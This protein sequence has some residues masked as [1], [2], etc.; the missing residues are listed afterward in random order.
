LLGGLFL[1]VLAREQTAFSIA[2]WSILLY[3]GWTMIKLSHD[4]WGAELSQDYQERLRITA[5]REALALFGGILAIGLIGYGVLPQGPQG[6]APG[7]GVAF[8]MLY[9]AMAGLLIA[10]LFGALCTTPDPPIVHTKRFWP[11]LWADC[12]SLKTTIGQN[13]PLQKLSIAFFLNGLAASLPGTLFLLFVEHVV[14]QPAAQG[15]LLL[16]YFITAVLATPFW[17]WA[18]QRFGKHQAWLGAML[19]ASL[20]FL[21][22][23]LLPFLGGQPVA[24]W[25]FAGISVLTG[26][27]LSGDVLLPPAI[28][29]DVLDED[30]LATGQERAGLLFAWLGLLQKLSLAAPIGFAFPLLAWVGFQPLTRNNTQALLVLTLLYA[31]LPIM[32]KLLACLALR[33]F[34]LDRTRLDLLQAKLGNRRS[35]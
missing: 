27:C 16:L 22:A 33:N 26:F 1:L 30:R 35:R 31:A 14:G 8:T 29:A 3:T 11:S 18:G 32:L 21:P 5:I 6:K 15:P 20:A 23:L 24:L 10:S 13:K 17:N 28:Q 7:L 9:F 34:P 19:L 25:L 4:A 2:L 12:L